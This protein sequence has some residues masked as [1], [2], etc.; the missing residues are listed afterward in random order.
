MAYTLAWSFTTP[1][2]WVQTPPIPW[3]IYNCVITISWVLLEIAFWGFTFNMYCSCSEVYNIQWVVQWKE[4]YF[5]P[6]VKSSFGSW[7]KT[8]E[9]NSKSR[10]CSFCFWWWTKQ[11]FFPLGPKC[12]V[13][14]QDSPSHEIYCFEIRFI[15]LK[16]AV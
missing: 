10:W 6:G 13:F 1:S 5:G 8:I 14:Q 3:F 12:R 9:F 11:L 16:H 4:L 2:V 15:I 7:I